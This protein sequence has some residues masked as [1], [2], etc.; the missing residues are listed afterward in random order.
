MLNKTY[1]YFCS[2]NCESVYVYEWLLICIILQWLLQCRNHFILENICF[3]AVWA[4]F[5]IY[6][7]NYVTME[8]FIKFQSS[9]PGR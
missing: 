1:T 6:V 4:C 2:I 3:A 7:A 9:F 5:L 8:I